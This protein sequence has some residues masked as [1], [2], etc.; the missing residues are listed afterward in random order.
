[1]EQIRPLV[2][3]LSSV[4]FKVV[5]EEMVQLL[6][7]PEDKVLIFLIMHELLCDHVMLLVD[8]TVVTLQLVVRVVP[9]FFVRG[10]TT[11]MVQITD[12]RV[13]N[14]GAVGTGGSPTA[15]SG[16][17]ITAGSNI[18]VTNNNVLSCPGTGILVGAAL[19]NVQV[20]SNR[21][22]NCGTGF[23]NSA[24]SGTQAVFGN[25]VATLNTT[26]YS[27]GILLTGA[28]SLTQGYWAN[29]TQ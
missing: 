5:M 27:A 16:I 3:L 15:G 1:M 20:M 2:R 29:V 4:L 12:C 6:A 7:V 10:T 25:N 21:V 28:M 19:T 23:S 18:Q 8:L 22:S 24:G 9:V 14:T 26:N 17:G 13:E 11:T